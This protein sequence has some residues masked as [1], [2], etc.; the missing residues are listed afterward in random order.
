MRRFGL[1]LAAAVGAVGVFAAAAVVGASQTHPAADLLT[2][3]VASVVQAR[4]T[5]VATALPRGRSGAAAVRPER[6]LAGTIQSVGPDS[7]QVVGVGG[8]T[9]TIEPVAGA[10]IRLN[11]KAAKLESLHAGDTVVILGQRQAGP[12]LRFVAHAVTAKS[13]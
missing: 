6:S 11:G 5:I 1:H 8:R 13:K 2:Q 3:P 12:G 10:L 4:P 9:W 7:L